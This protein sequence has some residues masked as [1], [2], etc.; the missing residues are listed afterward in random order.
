MPRERPYI[1]EEIEGSRPK[2]QF[3]PKDKPSSLK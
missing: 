3:I 2:K 1:P